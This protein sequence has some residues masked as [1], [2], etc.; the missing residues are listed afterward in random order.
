MHELLHRRDLR[1][2]EGFL[3][4]VIRLSDFLEGVV[5]PDRWCDRARR[6]AEQIDPLGSELGDKQQ[7]IIKDRL[8]TILAQLRLA[9][10]IYEDEVPDGKWAGTMAESLIEPITDGLDQLNAKNWQG[11]ADRI[12]NFCKPRLSSPKGLAEMAAKVVAGLQ[13]NAVEAFVSL[14][15][16]ALLNPNYLDIVGRSASLQTHVL[17]ELVQR[18]NK[19]YAQRKSSLN[20]LDFADL[21]RYMLKLLTAE[22]SFGERLS[23][24]ETGLALRTRFKH[25]FVDEYQDINPVQQAILDALS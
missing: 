16:L 8:G 13:K 10:R 20:G 18:F 7:Q 24:S 19:L 15:D 2:S 17:I 11:C 3:G 5:S 1:G 12:R 22:D 9:K 21:E 6:L 14:N 25:I 23:P 4:G